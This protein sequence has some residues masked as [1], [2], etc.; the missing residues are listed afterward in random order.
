[1]TSTHCIATLVAAGL[2]VSGL[3]A[4]TLA[5]QAAARTLEPEPAARPVQLEVDVGGLSGYEGFDPTIYDTMTQQALS[6]ALESRGVE[7]A[8]DGTEGADRVRIGLV[9]RDFDASVYEIEVA[10]TRAGG[11]SRTLPSQLCEYCTDDELVAKAESQLD[12]ALEVLA[13]SEPQEPVET[14]TGDGGTVVADPPVAEEPTERK[15]LAPLAGVGI[16]V[17]AVG[18]A[19]LITGGVLFGRDDQVGFAPDGGLELETTS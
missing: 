1:M 15:G 11:E 3:P 16:G 17:A 19:G 13:K 12:A 7:Q 18:V 4:R 14:D 5:A 8:D 2:L 9:W 10:V 6:R